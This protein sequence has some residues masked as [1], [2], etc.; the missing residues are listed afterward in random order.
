[1]ADV[2]RNI[3]LRNGGVALVDEADFTSVR[4]HQWSW[5]GGYAVGRIL[6]DGE[7]RSTSIHRFLMGPGPGQQCDH[8]SGDKLDNRRANLRL[9]TVSQNVCNRPAQSNNWSGLKGVSY[10]RGSWIARIGL[11]RKRYHIGCY[12]TATEA[13]RAYDARAKELHGEFA[14]LNF[15]EEAAA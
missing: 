9:C 8:I 14:R 10:V 15:P 1:M 11:N 5:S 2:P 3:A 4:A 6:I 12:R 13:A 7:W